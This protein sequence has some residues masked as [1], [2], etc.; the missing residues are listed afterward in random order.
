MEPM[1][2]FAQSGKFAFP[3]IFWTYTSTLAPMIEKGTQEI[4]LGTTTPDQLVKDL[5]AKQAELTNQ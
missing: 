5:D 1:K 4:V 2:A 3:P